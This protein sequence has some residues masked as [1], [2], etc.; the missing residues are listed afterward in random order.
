MHKL[1]KMTIQAEFDVPDSA[2]Q[3]LL[4]LLLENLSDALSK[5]AD[6]VENF[7]K[8]DLDALRGNDLSKFRVAL[9]AYVTAYPPI[10]DGEAGS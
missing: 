10:T 9:D 8:E 3:P 7:K 2:Y 1:L 4:D 5:A 6:L